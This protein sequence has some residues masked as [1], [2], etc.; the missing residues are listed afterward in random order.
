MD[1]PMSL[2]QASS[3]ADSAYM[4]QHHGQGNNFIVCNLKLASC[5]QSSLVCLHK[6]VQHLLM[7][8]LIAAGRDGRSSRLS[9]LR[10]GNSS[11]V[12]APQGVT[13]QGIAI[14]DFPSGHELDAANGIVS[15]DA[16]IEITRKLIVDS[17]K[18][19]HETCWN[20]VVAA[21]QK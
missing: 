1:H 21:L 10:G 3:L 9:N 15:E 17:L 19:S 8:N 16:A 5:F 12:L 11:R 2:L 4:I 18:A 6:P 13:T 14:A 20:S 7:S